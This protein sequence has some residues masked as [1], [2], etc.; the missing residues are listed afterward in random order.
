MSVI[1]NGILLASEAAAAGPFE[2]SRSLRFNSADSAYLNRTPGSAGNRKTW[3]WAGWVK[4]SALTSGFQTLFGA[5][6]G[7]SAEASIRFNSDDTI[8]FYSYTSGYNARLYTTQVFRDVSA[9]Y[10]IVAVFDT[11][12]ATADQRIRLYANGTEITT[13]I[14]RTNPTQNYDGYVNN[15]ISH[16]IGDAVS[17]A[18]P[19]FLNGY[20]A[21]VYFIDG[22][23]LDPT[24]FGEFDAT[25]GVWNPI[26]YTGSYGTNGFHLTFSDNSGTTSTT[27][28][29]DAAGSNNWTPNNFSVASGSGND[30]L[31]DVPQNGDQTDTGA[32]GEVRGNYCTLNPLLPGNNSYSNGNLDSSF[33]SGATVGYGQRQW[34]TIGVSSGKWYFEYVQTSGYV[35]GVGI[36]STITGDNLNNYVYVA[37]ATKLDASGSTSSYGAS[38]A[39]ND[40]VGVAFDLDAGTITFYLNGVSQGQAFS[41]IAAGTYFPFLL[42]WS[43]GNS[44]Q[45]VNFGQRAF[46]YSA[47]SGFKALCT[48]SLPTPTIEDGSAYMDVKLYQGN[49]G[50]NTISGLGFSPDF[51]WIKNRPYVY[52]HVLFDAVRGTTKILKSNSTAAESTQSTSLTSFNS[53]GFTLGA[54][55]SGEYNFSSAHNYV[56]WCWDAGSSTVSN[57][58]GSITSSVRAN[59]SAGFS[60]VTYSGTLAADTVGHGLGVAPGMIIFKQRGSSVQDWRVYHSSVGAGK[61]ARLNTTA[62]FATQTTDFT[63]VSSTTFTLGVSS[64]TNEGNMLAYCFA[65]VAGYSAFGSYTGNGSSDG[66]FVYTGHRTRWLMVKRT[67]SAIDWIVIDTA[68]SDYNQARAE[69]YPNDPA[70]EGTN[71]GPIDINSNGFKLRTNSSSWNASGGTYVYAC[72]SENPFKYA[73]AR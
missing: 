67:D 37:G 39:L 33:T 14:A 63:A 27:L 32:G 6:T 70:A 51:V 48:A 12:N 68:R 22:Q 56:A 31:V 3:T 55:G 66:P 71:G 61:S 10:H 5:G 69:L 20:L 23:A 41:G 7:G 29:K 47:P 34:G 58:Q 35:Q 25:T 30:S 46:A 49:G 38:I 64:A 62:A 18:S 9:W 43:G 59:A 72:F 45:T 26:E 1:N 52:D 17:G 40:V 21:D 73:R 65:P 50:T 36:K 15:S 28:G 2:I 16:T 4:R 60:I 54:D 13:F 8:E 44:G 53:D 57:T 24:S 11:P 42:G 19:R